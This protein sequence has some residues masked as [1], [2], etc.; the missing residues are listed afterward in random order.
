MSRAG[1]ALTEAL[2]RWGLLR[3]V[4]AARRAG[5]FPYGGLTVLAYH[6]V[7]PEGAVGELDPEM[8][9]ATPEELD[10]QMA[11][12]RQVFTPVS[13]DEVREAR[14]QGRPLPPDSVLVTFDDGYVDNF[15]IAFPILRRHGIRAAFFVATAAVR[16]RQLFWWERVHL[17]ISRASAVRLRIDYPRP[18][19]LDLSTARARRRAITRV[20][21]IVKRHYG[22]DV[23]RF[24]NAIAAACGT[25]WSA[26]EGR[27]RGD[28][29]LL[30]WD[31]LR[32]MR[33]AGMAVASHSHAHFG[34]ETLTPAAL[35]ADLTASRDALEAE[36]GEPVRT[37]AYPFGHSVV[38]TPPV[39]RAVAEAGFDLGFRLGG[40]INRLAAGEDPLDIRR[41]TVDRILPTA[42]A[43]TWMTFPF[44]AP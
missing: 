7:L 35:A 29:A 2:D 1:Q 33:A 36:L 12:L 5:L 42:M 19:E 13:L 31:Q 38:A 24:L 37:I 44:L 25:S 18:E 40:G 32:E 41:L 28:R 23:E 4:N 27:A 9:D 22:L 17:L 3:L 26:A 15:E 6:R 20:C 8:N 16:D 34:L 11:H 14:R 43:R 21:Q 39:R 10:A 30:T